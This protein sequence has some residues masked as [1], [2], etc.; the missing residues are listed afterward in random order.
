MRAPVALSRCL[1]I[2][3]IVSKSVRPAFSFQR[4]RRCHIGA[5]V[6]STHA[7]AR[8]IIAIFEALSEGIFGRAEI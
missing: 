4:T 5:S 1:S 7:A 8:P 3:P 2:S 6:E